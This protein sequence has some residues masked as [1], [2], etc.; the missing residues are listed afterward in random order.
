MKIAFFFPA[1]LVVANFPGNWILSPVS[2]APLQLFTLDRYPWY[3]TKTGKVKSKPLQEGQSY[4]LLEIE[5]GTFLPLTTT[6]DVPG[7]IEDH[8]A[9]FAESLPVWRGW[10]ADPDRYEAEQAEKR[11]KVKAEREAA[12]REQEARNAA[13]AEAAQAAYVQR[14]A[15]FAGGTDQIPVE[16]F[17]H[18]CKEQGIKMPIQTVGW[19][20]E[21]I[22][23]V[24]R[25]GATMTGRTKHN[26]PHF[27]AAVRSL[28][29]ALQ[30]V[31]A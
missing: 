28:Y 16:D 22:K 31:N 7:L 10:L 18:A 30:A 4:L 26:S 29:E 20:R 5:P 23:S 27:W 24:G 9:H 12:D 3:C 21:N 14:L 1:K 11:V 25:N 17:E 19:M 2:G 13:R 6:G 15:S 8:A